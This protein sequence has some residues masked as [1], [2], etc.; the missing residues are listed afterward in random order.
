MSMFEPTVYDSPAQFGLEIVGDAEWA[1]EPYRFDLT[2]IWKNSDGEYLVASDSGCSCP[3]PFEEYTK[4]DLTVMSR[5]DIFVLLKDKIADAHEDDDLR[6]T[7]G[8]RL[9][10]RMMTA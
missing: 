7:E 1:D 3:E 10:E 8:V 9:L 6:E 2:V 5:Q 4:D